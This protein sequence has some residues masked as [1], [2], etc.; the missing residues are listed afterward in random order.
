MD[1][2][3]LEQ[4]K[5]VCCQLDDAKVTVRK[6]AEEQLRHSLSNSRTVQALTAASRSGTS[7][8]WSWQEVYRTTFNFVKKETDK[9]IQDLQKESRAKPSTSAATARENRKTSVMGLFKLVVRE[10]RSCLSW[11]SVISDLLGMISHSYMRTAFAEELLTLLCQAVSNPASRAMI[12]VTSERNQ[13]ADILTTVLDILEDPPERLESLMVARL[14]QLS[15]HHGV[16][17]AV[18]TSVVSSP[19]MWRLMTEV[20]LSEKIA[21]HDSDAKLE[22]VRAANCLA[23][24]QCL[25]MRR[26]AVQ[27]GEKVIQA[28]ILVWDDWRPERTEAVLEFMRLQMIVHHPGGESEVEAGAL[29]QDRELWTRQLKRI[30]KNLVLTTIAKKQKQNK[31]KNSR[32]LDDFRLPTALVRL[33]GA[34]IYQLEQVPDCE[35]RADVTQI[36]TLDDTQAS[37]AHGPQAKRRR[38]EEEEVKYDVDLLVRELLKQTGLEELKVAWLQLLVEVVRRFPSTVA[39]RKENLVRLAAS[40]LTESRVGGVREEVVALVAA[41]IPLT[42][43]RLA[44]WAAVSQ[45]VTTLLATNQLRQRGHAL[46]RLLINRADAFN[47]NVKDIYRPYESKNLTLDTQSVTTLLM[48]LEKF[49]TWD[50]SFTQTRLEVVF[51]LEDQLTAEKCPLTEFDNPSLIGRLLHKLTVKVNSSLVR[52]N[53]SVGSP[54][55]QEGAE[56]EE[57]LEDQLRLL[58]CQSHDSVLPTVPGR[59]EEA[60]GRAVK[61]PQISGRVEE[62]LVMVGGHLLNSLHSS[63]EAAQ[64]KLC[65]S[66]LP[67]LLEFLSLAGHQIRILNFTQQL[68]TKVLDTTGKMFR[69]RE[70]RVRVSL[71]SVLS[72]ITKSLQVNPQYVQIL[73][74]CPNKPSIVKFS[75]ILQKEIIEICKSKEKMTSTRSTPNSSSASTSRSETPDS[76]DDFDDMEVQ[77]EDSEDFELTNSSDTSKAQQE[78]S[79]AC[80]SL[81]LLAALSPVTDKDME[82]VGI[83]QKML[84]TFQYS[85]PVMK[86]ILPCLTLI[87]S[88]FN[89]E[90]L[91]KIGDLLM[92]LAKNFVTPKKFIMSGLV[93]LCKILV[94]V[95]PSLGV[96]DTHTRDICAKILRALFKQNLISGGARLSASVLTSLCHVTGELLKLGPGADWAVWDLHNETAPA[97]AV[98]TVQQQLISRSLPGLLVCPLPAVRIAAIR[99]VTSH[100]ATA[101]TKLTVVRNS[102][103]PVIRSDLSH[104]SSHSALLSVITR[105]TSNTESEALALL[106]KLFSRDHIDLHQLQRAARLL[107]GPG[108]QERLEELLTKFLPAILLDFV[109]EGLGLNKFPIVLL[110]FAEN[111]FEQF[112]KRHE[113]VVVSIML[114]HSPT[115]ECLKVLTKVL[116]KRNSLDVI[117]DNFPHIALLFLPGLAATEFN[118]SFDDVENSRDLANFIERKVGE[119]F[120]TA[121]QRNLLKVLGQIYLNVNDPETLSDTFKIKKPEKFSTNPPELKAVIPCHIVDLLDQQV[122]IRKELV[123]LNPEGFVRT[124]V[125]ITSTVS[126]DSSLQE[127]MRG[128]HSLHLWLDSLVTSYCEEMLPI[129]SFLSQYLSRRLLSFLH[130]TCSP[131]FTKMSLTVLARLVQFVLDTDHSALLPVFL[132]VHYSLVNF[133]LV[134]READSAQLAVDILENLVVINGHR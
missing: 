114:Y 129:V 38:L 71:T 134:K 8:H 69:S 31:Q 76:F 51:W 17:E 91:D 44:D 35:S 124:T 30:F 58:T 28:V 20:L 75:D 123:K 6:K 50:P 41:L 90:L 9:M 73:K 43:D 19:R 11:S 70:E 110:G 87:S 122:N 15:L 131:D 97:L 53:T 34:V 29:Y 37:Q 10:G 16:R 102:L 121:I 22:F 67:C 115:E 104:G 60:G 4:V 36:L 26:E 62:L 78:E 46:L 119:N 89:D 48:V 3:Q 2:S 94:F 113:S 81:L 96:H 64:L 106:I 18:V 32:L 47:I 99:L 116:K 82:A 7:R 130:H 57:E 14:L 74:N 55:G 5:V 100:L 118:L 56:E 93:T 27:L 88:T 83:L 111:Q 49:P 25:H 133:L 85:R 77:V 59:R 109:Q 52:V 68:L 84:E 42:E 132:T 33:G 126:Q 80:E 23:R 105:L 39:R 72:S 98:D 127:N 101:D 117:K 13:W 108:S 65:S 107:A 125:S 63:S 92:D 61:L 54:E 79:L 103:L 112:V 128:L 66:Y 95:I 24:S 45:S 1:Y 21:R 40:Q 86:T 12:S 120:A